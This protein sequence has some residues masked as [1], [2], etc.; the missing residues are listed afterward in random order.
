MDAGTADAVLRRFMTSDSAQRA[1]IGAWEHGG[2][3]HASPY[4]PADA[5]ADPPLPEQWAEMVSFFDMH[6][7][8]NDA[9]PEKLLFYYTMGEERWKKSAV[10]PPKGTV[11]R[12]WYLGEGNELSQEEPTV[13]TGVDRYAV[14]FEASTGDHNRWWEMGGIWDH[15]VI[16]QDRRAETERLL[17]YSTPPLAE[18][19]EITGYPVVTLYVASTE[20]DGV[21][22][23]YLEDEDEEG[24]VTYLTEGQL[25]II[26]RKV[27]NEPAPYQLL[28]PYHSF[29]EGDAMPLVPGEVAEISFGLL[30]TSVLIRK[31]HRI[32]IAIAGHDA[33]TFPRIPA[34]GVPILTVHRNSVY[35]SS[36]DLPVA[37]KRE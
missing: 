12:R 29:K 28:V 19:M 33:G 23:L 4:Q 25:R 15:S 30:P 36:I 16:Y 2:R 10:W 13:E 31:G 34:E 11:D 18:D 7:K 26:H 20:A 14:D 37:R 6:L 5:V 21:I 17:T 27:S 8:E 9:R 1:V 22:Y 3:F 32:R 35:P 24:R